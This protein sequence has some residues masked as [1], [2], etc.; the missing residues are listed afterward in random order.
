[1][2]KRIRLGA[3]I[4]ALLM[5]FCAVSV[6]AYDP[7]W[8]EFEKIGNIKENTHI[9]FDMSVEGS[10]M[11]F[12]SVNGAAYTYDLNVV[13]NN[14]RTKAGA[15]GTAEFKMPMLDTMK[16]NVWMDYDFE[17]ADD[18]KY[19]MILKSVS[20]ILDSQIGDKYLVMDFGKISYLKEIIPAVVSV[21][22]EYAAENNPK[23]E[24]LKEEIYSALDAIKPV[25]DGDAYVLSISMGDFKKIISDNRDKISE[26][27]KEALK[28][29]GKD[30]VTDE[31]IDKIFDEQ[32]NKVF[33]A[34]EKIDISGLE[35]KIKTT[36][37]PN[38]GSGASEIYC[39]MSLDVDLYKLGEE[40]SLNQSDNVS[41]N[42]AVELNKDMYKGS[43]KI[44]LNGMSEPL[45]SDYK[46]DFPEIDNS[47]SIDVFD[48]LTA[49]YF[50][51]MFNGEA[52]S[53]GIIPDNNGGY[54]E[55]KIKYNGRELSF[56][57]RPFVKQDRTFIAL[58]ELANMLGISDENISYDEATEK[59]SISRSDISIEMQ[60][61]S[62][63]VKV[64]GKEL[65]L[66]VPAFTVNDRTYIPVRFIS[67]MFG[68][69]VDYNDKDNVLTVTIDD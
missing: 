65:T 22:K 9:K 28:K 57:N 55:I 20:G 69:N 27:I 8:D 62:Q 25:K 21:L 24:E 1:M 2:N 37:K 53:V 48:G 54:N 17:S 32:I 59:I 49:L 23:I 15:S 50:G 44:K 52:K 38:G 41:A 66:D 51:N 68:K 43:L 60:I 34:I 42:E 35:F 13:T 67:E 18:F 31:Q 36:I 14:D 6:N 3:L 33:D 58:R 56:K 61:G 26:L 47:N 4:T 16:M 10:G 19:K 11:M 39:E 29:I 46:I 5:L 40:L 30:G 64:N 63:A 45:G 12:A 7:V